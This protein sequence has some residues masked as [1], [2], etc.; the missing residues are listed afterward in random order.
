MSLDKT[1]AKAGDEGWGE[2][3]KIVLQ[4]LAIA[5][6]VRI[7]LYQPF[8]IPSG[9]MKDT[10][11]VGDYIFVSKLSYGLSRYSFPRTLNLCM[12]LTGWCTGD[13]TIL[14]DMVGKDQ[15]IFA[16]EPKRGDVVVFR[17]PS[18]PS[19]DY[20]KRLVGLPGDK[21][22]MKDGVLFINGAAVPKVPDGSFDN[23]DCQDGYDCVQHHYG[24]FKETLPN[25][26]TH[27]TLD[28]EP[29]DAD[30]RG[31]FVV[32]EGNY[33][34]MGDNRDNSIDSRFLKGVGFVPY[35]NLIGRADVIF[36]SCESEQ[37]GTCS[38]FKPWNWPF[39]I[40]WSRLFKAVK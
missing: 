27:G 28:R 20:I 16:S 2:T 4:A 11:L 32:P 9:S 39:E 23:I 25:N 31:P 29:T 18:N 3:L 24:K 33:F 19:I 37:A 34:M 40:R 12:P 13:F 22:E 1:I 7:F 35:E 10:L 14:P 36:Y 30:N 15:R 38:W 26:V 17:L 21:I 5:L 6:V 8:N